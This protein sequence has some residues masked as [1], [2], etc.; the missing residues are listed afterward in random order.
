[1]T[2]AE[3][4]LWYWLRA[5]RF[6]DVAFRR[7][8]PI[9]QF[10]VDFVSHECRLIIEIDGGQ[11]N[12]NKADASR[13]QWL[14]S[15]GY[16]V[17]RFWNSDILKNRDAVLERIADGISLARPPSRQSRTP[18]AIGDLPLKGGGENSFSQRREQRGKIP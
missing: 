12:E 15:K 4:R 9:G 11:H 18:S 2:E 5:H 7:Q 1:M 13:D 10:I 6:Q 3:K 8:T 14:Y 16:R 17:L